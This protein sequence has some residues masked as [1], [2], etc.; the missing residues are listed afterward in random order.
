[1]VSVTYKRLAFLSADIFSATLGHRLRSFY[2]H[3]IL[4]DSINHQALII[5]Y[6]VFL[7]M[8]VTSVCKSVYVYYYYVCMVRL[9]YYTDV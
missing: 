3:P 1:M 4:K 6:Y 7:Y 5:V 9:F 8:H 2:H